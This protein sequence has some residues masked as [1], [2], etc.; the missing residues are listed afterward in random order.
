MVEL[1]STGLL[2]D[3]DGVLVDSTPAVARV[4]R[5]WA[6]AHGFDPE[7]TVR[8]AHGRPS[9]ET[10]RDLLPTA[11][12]EEENRVILRGEIEDIEGVVPLPGA[13]ELLNSLPEERWA[14]VTSCARSLAEVRLRTAGLPI[15]SRMI[16]CDDVRKGKPDPE[17]YRKGAELLGV[18]ASECVVFEDAPAGIRA[19]KAA[20]ARVIALRST[21]PDLELEQAGADW[22]LASY[23]NLTVVAC[24]HGSNQLKLLIQL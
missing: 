20:G 5:R 7:E 19:G 9:V 22:I 15:P 21:S 1:T 23:H 16:T 8:R 10:V 2:F 3:L 17:P 4:W 12:T 11:D 13:R 24:D 14:V 6:I 18:R